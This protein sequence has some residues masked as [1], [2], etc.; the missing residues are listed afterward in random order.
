VSNAVIRGMLSVLQSY[1]EAEHQEW[2]FRVAPVLALASPSRKTDSIASCR[3]LGPWRPCRQGGMLV[4]GR[5]SESEPDPTCLG[6]SGR[7]RGM[8]QR[9]RRDVLINN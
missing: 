7:P 9:R 1:D 4:A 5:E 6:A 2:K 3:Q 8:L